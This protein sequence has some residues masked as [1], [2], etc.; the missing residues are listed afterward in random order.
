[1]RRDQMNFVEV[2][3]LRKQ[4]GKL[5]AVDGVSFEIR[6]GEVFSL[7]GPNGAGK[8]TTIG[9][10][11]ALIEPAVGIDPQNRRSILDLILQINRD[12]TTILYTTGMQRG[13]K[14]SRRCW[15]RWWTYFPKAPTPM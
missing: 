10:L 3:E 1:M 2:K 13:P 14:R 4:Y 9:M 11:S 7:L 6:E 15:R 5:A 12:G 8:S